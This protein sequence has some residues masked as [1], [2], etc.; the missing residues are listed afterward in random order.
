MKPDRPSGQSGRWRTR[1]YGILGEIHMALV[2]VAGSL[3]VVG[4]ILAYGVQFKF[5]TTAL[6]LCLGYLV[7]DLIRITFLRGKTIS[8]GFPLILMAFLILDSLVLALLIAVIGS[9][10]SELVYSKVLS[11][12]RRPLGMAIVRA[13][14]Y[15]GHHA[16]AG[17]GALYAF[18]VTNVWIVSRNNSFK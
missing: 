17:A 12:Q 18:T 3:I 11:K 4:G 16:V 15:A 9:L 8:L 5:D 14:F 13:L 1:L 10:I 2:T 6:L 7:C